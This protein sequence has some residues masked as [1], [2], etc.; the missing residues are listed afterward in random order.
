MSRLLLLTRRA[1]QPRLGLLTAQRARLRKRMRQGWTSSGGKR[2]RGLP[3]MQ[4]TS[5]E[6]SIPTRVGEDGL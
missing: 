5:L 4:T 6:T 3:A 1:V 2:L